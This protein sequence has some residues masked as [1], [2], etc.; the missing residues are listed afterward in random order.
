[1]DKMKAHVDVLVA[2][3]CD[4]IICHGDT[5]VVILPD[6]SELPL[7]KPS[8]MSTCRRKYVS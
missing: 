3:G 6:T 4:V 1:L 8:S 7:G 2:G 5:S